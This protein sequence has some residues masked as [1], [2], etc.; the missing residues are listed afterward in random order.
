M[1]GQREF[2]FGDLCDRYWKTFQ[3]DWERLASLT[4]VGFS[5]SECE[6]F[7]EDHSWPSFAG[8]RSSSAVTRTEDS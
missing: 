5:R 4:R 8:S 6:A 1:L 7:L 2:H 3:T